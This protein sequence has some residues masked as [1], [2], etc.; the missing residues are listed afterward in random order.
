MRAHTSRASRS[1]AILGPGVGNPERM[2]CCSMAGLHLVT[3]RP[4]ME[5]SGEWPRKCRL[6]EGDWT[7]EIKDMPKF[8]PHHLC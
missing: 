2:K 1:A 5:P 8:T 4:I 3:E 7:R 6:E